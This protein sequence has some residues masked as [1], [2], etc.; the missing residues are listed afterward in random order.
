MKVII[1]GCGRL[2]SGMARDLSMRG[3]EVTV[4]DMDPLAFERLGKGLKIKTIAGIGFD[5]DVLVKAGIET[6]DSLAAVTSSDEANVVSARIAKM[7]FRVPRVAARVYD[8]RKAEIYRRLGIPTISPVA[9]TAARIAEL[10]TFSNLNT[11][12]SLGS[13]EVNIVEIDATDLLAGQT[14]D[15][16]SLPGKALVVSI[17]R[18]GRSFMPHAATQIEYGDVLHLAVMGDDMD[19]IAS[20]LG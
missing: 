8:P 17:T 18:M 16:L 20:L 5:R 1:I 7:V 13:G 15:H 4:V 2:G 14:I 10:L 19:R 9:T 12:V 3:N 11:L 6:A